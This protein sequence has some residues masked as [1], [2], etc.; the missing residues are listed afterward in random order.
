MR[1][2][3]VTLLLCLSVSLSVFSETVVLKSG[4][5]IESKIV[6]KT[7]SYVTLDFHGIPLRYYMDG[8]KTIY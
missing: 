8:I 5:R 7:D 4:T 6:E 3:F 2:F 1:I